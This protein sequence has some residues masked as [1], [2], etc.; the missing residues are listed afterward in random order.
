MIDPITK[1]LKFN[2]KFDQL[3]APKVTHFFTLSDS[4]YLMSNKYAFQWDTY[5][6]LQW[7]PGGGVL[8]PFT[9]TP[10]DRDPPPLRR[11]MGPGTETSPQ[12]EHGARQPD[13]K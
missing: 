12:K 3:Y 4:L 2:P 9:E 6:P 11:N 10:L 7:P 5:R 1:E 8:S 13:R